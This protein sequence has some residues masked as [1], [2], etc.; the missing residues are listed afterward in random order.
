[1]PDSS[2]PKMKHQNSDKTAEACDSAVLDADYINK[3]QIKRYVGRGP[4][5]RYHGVWQPAQWRAEVFWFSNLEALSI[6][7]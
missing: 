4:K 2:F 1:M 5:Q 7:V 6:H 3:N